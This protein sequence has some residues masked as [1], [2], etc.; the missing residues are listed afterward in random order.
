MPGSLPVPEFHEGSPG[1]K[2]KDY[3]CKDPAGEAE[4]PRYSEVQPGY[5]QGN[6]GD[7]PDEGIRDQGDYQDNEDRGLHQLDFQHPELLIRKHCLALLKDALVHFPVMH[8]CVRNCGVGK[9]CIVGFLKLEAALRTENSGII[10]FIT[11]VRTLHTG[12]ISGLP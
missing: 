8:G 9:R 10:H 7:R 11:A 12:Y 6:E 5:S 3:T 2:E 4:D 1:K